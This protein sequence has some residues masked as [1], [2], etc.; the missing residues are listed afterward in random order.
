MRKKT[1]KTVAEAIGN[2]SLGFSTAD[3]VAD[4]CLEDLKKRELLIESGQYDFKTDLDL[5]N[6]Y[7]Q[8]SLSS[9]NIDDTSVPADPLIYHKNDAVINKVNDE[10]PTS[11]GITDISVSNG[12][13]VFTDS[14]GK[15]RELELP[16]TKIVEKTVSGNAVN[17]K[18]EKILISDNCFQFKLR[19]GKRPAPHF[20]F[21]Y[22]EEGVK[23]NPQI[24]WTK[25]ELI[26]DSNVDLKNHIII[27]G[28]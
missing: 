1:K 24:S 22:D 26:V 25:T 7:S 5:A 17:R 27:I 16:T 23:C 11:V 6:Y 12:N 4:L 19:I 10:P 18:P 14:D 13:L 2:M 15:R 20:V 21:L 9:S 8:K 28:V 3:V